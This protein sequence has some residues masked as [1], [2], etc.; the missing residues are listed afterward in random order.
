MSSDRLDDAMTGLTG[1]AIATAVMTA[2]RAPIARSPPPPAWF[3]AEYVAGGD[4]DEYLLPSL[5]LHFAYGIGGGAVFGVLAGP[6]LGGSEVTRERCGALLGV[7]YGIA[8]SG[9]GAVVVLDTLLGLDLEADERFVF[10]VSHVIYGL[11]LGTWLGSREET[12]DNS[13]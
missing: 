9:F 6:L 13:R 1:G 4:P 5:L 8:L 7:L 2:F 11:T 12:T 10:H 3:W